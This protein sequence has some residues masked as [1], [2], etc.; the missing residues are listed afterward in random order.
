M[1][2]AAILAFLAGC[3]F[4]ITGGSLADDANP[5]EGG[6][7]T[8]GDVEDASAL[9]DALLPDQ[10]IMSVE[11]CDV[12][13]SG[14]TALGELL[15]GS[16]GAHAG[17]VSCGGNQV[18]VGLQFDVTPAGIA[19]HNNQILMTTIRLWCGSIRRT[20]MNQMVTENLG[21]S[22]YTGLQGS[23]ATACNAYMPPVQL[24]QV[25]CPPGAVLVAINGHQ[26]DT[27]LYN[28]LSIQ[29]AAVATNGT[30][31]T[32]IV[33][34]AMPGTGTNALQSERTQ[35]PAS[36]AITAIHATSGCGQDGAT[37]SCNATMCEGGGG[38]GG[39]GP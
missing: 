21:V 14:A 5:S 8:D 36:T 37:A 19:G 20:S 2:R 3:G 13:R 32:S 25:M 10:P 23:T 17:D 27:T 24:A 38:G 31:T 6:S 33:E 15:G 11:E 35:C 29:C 34:I 22:S 16:G 1:E 12:G 9:A 26:V 18:G 4:H 30:I 39:G 28:N 7:T